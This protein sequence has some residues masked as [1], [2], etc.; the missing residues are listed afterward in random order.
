MRLIPPLILC[1]FLTP[2][3]NHREALWLHTAILEP[4]K[5]PDSLRTA[6]T[7]LRTQTWRVDH[8]TPEF[9]NIFPET[10]AAPKTHR[11]KAF[12]NTTAVYKPE[13][14]PDRVIRAQ[15][16]NQYAAAA[17]RYRTDS[18]APYR[19]HATR[20]FL[21]P[22]RNTITPEQARPDSPA[23]PITHRFY[24]VIEPRATLSNMLQLSEEQQEQLSTAL[25]LA[26]I[27]DISRENI[28]QCPDG[29]VIILDVENLYY[30]KVSLTQTHKEVQ[31]LI[32]SRGAQCP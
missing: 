11:P 7:F 8:T 25:W 16:V 31:K 29:S 28:A 15:I 27:N 32:P 1:L 18:T 12:M 22:Y 24:A 20:T 14:D 6:A 26:D 21:A 9:K 2:H 3:P 30:E 13:A 19:V 23:S 5:T 17:H 10:N 4:H